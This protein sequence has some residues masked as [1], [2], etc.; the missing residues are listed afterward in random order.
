MAKATEYIDLT[1]ALSL[2]AFGLEIT[3]DAFA[4]AMNVEH[5]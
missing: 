4:K 1:S 5:F 2:V 3:G